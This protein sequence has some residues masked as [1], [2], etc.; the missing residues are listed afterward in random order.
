VVETG[1]RF[2]EAHVEVVLAGTAGLI[3]KS[4]DPCDGFTPQ[5]RG[6]SYGVVTQ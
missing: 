6:P 5:Q 2:D 3:A 1:V 4:A